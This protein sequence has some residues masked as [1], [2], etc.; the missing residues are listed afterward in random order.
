[1]ASREAKTFFIFF[2]YIFFLFMERMWK[3]LGRKEKSGK[4]VCGGGGG[5]YPVST[6]TLTQAVD[7]KQNYS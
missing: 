1:M 6:Y 4:C 7:R 3:M 2:R 5:E